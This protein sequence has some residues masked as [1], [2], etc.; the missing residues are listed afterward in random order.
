MARQTERTTT[1][2]AAMVGVVGDTLPLGLGIA[3]NPLAIVAGI[4][5]VSKAGARINGLFFTIGWVIGLFVVILLTSLFIQ[6]RANAQPHETRTI[7]VVG[8]IVCGVMLIAISV[9]EL[10]NRPPPGQERPPPRWMRLLDNFGMVQSLA[11]GLF[12][13]IVSVKNLLLAAAAAAVIGQASLDTWRIVGTVTIFVT[14]C[15][16]GILIP[17]LVDVFGGEKADGILASWRAWFVLHAGALTALVMIVLGVHLVAKG[18][19]GLS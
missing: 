4:L 16:L 13:A 3:L 2:E 11:L 15:T 7:V 8:Q 10:L 14:I 6:A 12:L 18:I 9:R 17:L 5:I 19:S 1:G